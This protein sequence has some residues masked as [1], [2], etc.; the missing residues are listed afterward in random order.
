[1]VL[2]A[3]LA[4]ALA[5]CASAPPLPLRIDVHGQ[6]VDRQFRELVVR[7]TN[8]G[9]STLRNVHLDVAVP[10]SLPVIGDSQAESMTLD[11]TEA[12]G[13]QRIYHYTIPSLAPGRTAVAHLPF[14]TSSMATI[15]GKELTVTARLG[16]AKVET[17]RTL[18]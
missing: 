11:S 3:A 9:P 16:S 6:V 7:A 18:F 12:A 4:I 15:E 1:M 2:A 10:Q 5:S 13:D 17:K 8:D 14:R